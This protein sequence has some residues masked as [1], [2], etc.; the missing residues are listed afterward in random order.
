MKLPQ[1]SSLVLFLGVALA[2]TAGAC[3][4]HTDAADTGTQA[5]AQPAPA[6]NAPTA[7]RVMQRS[8]ERWQNVA[9][10]T[11]DGLVA[12]YEFN[13]PEVKHD[14]T[15]A[16]FLGRMQKHKYEAPHVDEVV[17]IKDNVAYVRTSVLWTSLDPL[18]KKV[19]LDPGQTLTQNITMI[20]T[21]HWVDGDWGYVRPQVDTDFFQD[22]PDLLKQDDGKQ[23]AK[24][25]EKPAQPKK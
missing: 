21:W 11:T 12:A 15:L 16:S 20:E 10:G 23:T 1:A 9:K 7:Q 18:A 3:G 14:Q 19:K 17:A 2:F 22:H 5:A 4:H 13:A 6:P 25:D 8:L 24:P